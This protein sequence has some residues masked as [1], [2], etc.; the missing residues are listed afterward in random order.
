MR[1]LALLKYASVIAFARQTRNGLPVPAGGKGKCEWC[2]LENPY[3]AVR[4][5]T[6]DGEPRL[7]VAARYANN[8]S[9]FKH[10]ALM[11]IV[12]EHMSKYNSLNSYPLVVNMK[13]LGAPSAIRAQRFAHPR[14]SHF[15]TT[16]L[17]QK[18]YERVPIEGAPC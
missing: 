7:V 8:C 9:R 11:T 5:S 1:R 2:I 13:A 3:L 10:I 14:A 6:Y 4:Q 15:P 17:A 18:T 12:I 16:A